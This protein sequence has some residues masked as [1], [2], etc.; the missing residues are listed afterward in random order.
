[1]NINEACPCRKENGD[2]TKRHVNC[3]SDCR[4]YKDWRAELDDLNLLKQRDSD[5]KAYCTE[6]VLK[7]IR[8]K[9]EKRN[10]RRR[11]PRTD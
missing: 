3:H 6:T 5:Y 7:K 2:C 8:R 10:F 1:M 11:N 9:N 4:E